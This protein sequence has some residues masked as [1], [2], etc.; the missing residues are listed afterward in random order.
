MNVVRAFLCMKVQ[1]IR[2][3]FSRCVASPPI[4]VAFGSFA[5]GLWPMALSPGPLASGLQV[6]GHGP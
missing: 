4:V 5:F 1:A 3:E 2:I 6:L